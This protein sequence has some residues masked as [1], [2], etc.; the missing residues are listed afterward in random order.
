MRRTPRGCF[1]K[2]RKQ[3]LIF[4]LLLFICLIGMTLLFIY[5]VQTAITFVCLAGLA[6]LY[7]LWLAADLITERDNDE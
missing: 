4:M 1:M 5:P 3:L 6:I 2:N 7:A